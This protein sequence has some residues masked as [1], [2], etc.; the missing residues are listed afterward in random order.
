MS[1]LVLLCLYHKANVQLVVQQ[2]VM[3]DHIQRVKTNVQLVL[4]D[5]IAL[6]VH[7]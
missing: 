2:L 3:L 4:L 5:I 7:I 1:V 6:E